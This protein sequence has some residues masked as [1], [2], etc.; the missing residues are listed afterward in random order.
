MMT[1]LW[2][3]GGAT[4]RTMVLRFFLLT[5]ES[6]EDLKNFSSPMSFLATPH[7]DSLKVC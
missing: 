6:R 4:W 1:S 7:T 2:R 5:D 3:E